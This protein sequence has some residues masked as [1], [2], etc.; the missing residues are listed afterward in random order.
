MAEPKNHHSDI[1]K[2]HFNKDLSAHYNINAAIR[3]GEQA[4]PS[5]SK[6]EANLGRQFKPDLQASCASGHISPS[7][8]LCYHLHSMSLSVTKCAAR[9]RNQRGERTAV[10]T[11]RAWSCK[12]DACI[13]FCV[14]EPT[15]GQPGCICLHDRHLPGPSPCLRNLSQDLSWGKTSRTDR[16]SN[17][18]GRKEG[19]N[20]ISK[21]IIH[22]PQW[23]E[24][25]YTGKQVLVNRYLIN[26]RKRVNFK[27]LYS[28]NR[29]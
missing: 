24:E 17:W 10:C 18:E 4:E 28:T 5:P 2:T 12:Q 16:K 1:H 13:T 6:A 9:S 7:K 3:T 14:G 23:I 26:D 27:M 20:A 19:E 25:E 21:M 22:L 15:K 8:D 29:V 11:L